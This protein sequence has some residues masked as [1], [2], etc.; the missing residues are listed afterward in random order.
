MNILVFEYLH[1]TASVFRAAPQSMRAEGR[2]M[3]QCL[4]NDLLTVP[5]VQ[6]TVAC[7]ADA[8]KAVPFSGEVRRV[9]ISDGDLSEITRQ[10]GTVARTQDIVI[11][12]APECDGILSHVVSTLRQGGHRVL[13][14]PDEAIKICSDKWRTDQLLRQL[15]LP[16]I[17]TVLANS[18]ENL[19]PA[20]GGWYVVK[21][22]D[23]AGCEGVFRTPADQLNQRLLS[24]YAPAE[25]FLLQPCLPG[26]A[27]SVAMLGQGPGRPPLILPLATQKITWTNDRPVYS[28]GAIPMNVP[29]FDTDLHDLCS[30]LASTLKLSEGYVG[31]DLLQPEGQTD[32]LITEINPRLCTSYTGYCRAASSSLAAHLLQIPDVPPI[33]WCAAEILF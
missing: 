10:L 11:P 25:A 20:A 4:V 17:P 28:G 14:A 9:A 15:H 30:Q 21:P 8:L 23:G 1:T 6:V 12:I 33:R 27:F 26:A 3:M 29:A 22:R 32:V 5:H 24:L 31:V 2:A 16:A 7:C 18:T 19:P 13:A